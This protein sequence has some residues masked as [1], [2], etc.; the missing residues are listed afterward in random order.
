MPKKPI[1]FKRINKYLADTGLAT[2]REVDKLVTA[3]LVTINGRKAV[4][5]DKVGPKDKVIL[6]K[7]Y[8][9]K[10]QTYL[11]YYKPR[12]VSTDKQRGSTSILETKKFPKGVFP[13]GRLDKDSEGLII[14][15]SDGRVTDRLLN[16]MYV[17]DKEYVVRVKGE[18]PDKV[19]QSFAEGMALNAT[20]KH[21]KEMTKP[22]KVARV[23][24]SVF[25]ITISEG[26]NRQ[27]RRMCETFKLHVEELKRIRVLNILIGKLK[28]NE[29]REFTSSELKVFLNKLGLK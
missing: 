29:F 17:H 8:S 28:P 12:G 20:E 1:E 18:I 21:G 3:G 27:I 9:P 6:S 24:G 11:A 22:A 13:V 5:G 26:K 7:S 10:K 2:R 23:N 4:L 14:L 19:L 25:N 15:T 16:P